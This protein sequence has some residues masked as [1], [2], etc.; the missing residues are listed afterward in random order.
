MTDIEF[1]TDFPDG[2]VGSDASLILD[3]NTGGFFAFT[4]TSTTTPSSTRRGL[5]EQRSTIGITSKPVTI[6][7]RP[8]RT[9][10]IRDEVLPG[11]LTRRDFVFVTSGRG[12]RPLEALGPH[13]GSRWESRLLVRE[14]RSGQDLRTLRKTTVLPGQRVKIHRTE[15]AEPG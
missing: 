5:R 13:G 6:M 8:V 12:T 9:E 10:D 7:G 1:M 11:H 4:T 15:C 14:F 2:E 3:R